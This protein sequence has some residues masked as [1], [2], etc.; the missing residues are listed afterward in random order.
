MASAS[1]DRN[2]DVMNSNS[3][4]KSGHRRALKGSEI[5]LEFNNQH[6]PTFLRKS[7]IKAHA[8]DDHD[9]LLNTVSFISV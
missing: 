4:K 1:P 8:H 6:D 3:I 7:P 5:P 2:I 9:S